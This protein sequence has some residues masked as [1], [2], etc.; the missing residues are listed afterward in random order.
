[1]PF[2][3]KSTR[4]PLARTRSTVSAAPAIGL[5]SPHPARVVRV[6]QR[7]VHVEDDRV[8]VGEQA[9]R[10]RRRTP[11]AVRSTSRSGR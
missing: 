3:K 10:A 9:H 7:A 8:D 2:V 6:E 1:M 5:R 11:G 4:R